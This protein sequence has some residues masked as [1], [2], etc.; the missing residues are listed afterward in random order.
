M[1]LSA[2][3]LEQLLARDR[4]LTNVNCYS[5]PLTLFSTNSPK[6]ANNTAPG[7]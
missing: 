7:T 2:K 5:F 3:H 6:A 1:S 4:N